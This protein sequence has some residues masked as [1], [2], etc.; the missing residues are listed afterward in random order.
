MPTVCVPDNI[1][2]LSFERKFVEKNSGKSEKKIKQF[3]T[4]RMFFAITGNN[5]LL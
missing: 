2:T 1:F 4:I 5:E 3:T